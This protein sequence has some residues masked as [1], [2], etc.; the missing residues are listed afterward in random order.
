ME[1]ILQS[2]FIATNAKTDEE[3]ARVAWRFSDAMWRRMGGV[4]L[5]FCREF[6]NLLQDQDWPWVKDLWS[7]DEVRADYKAMGIPQETID[8]LVK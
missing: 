5:G 4:P 1:A 3:K 8:M 6:N 2:L 7:A